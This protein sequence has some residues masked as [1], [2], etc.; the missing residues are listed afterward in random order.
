[1]DVALSQLMTLFSPLRQRQFA[2]LPGD[3]SRKI[4]EVRF[5]VGQPV[6][7]TVSGKTVFLRDEPTVTATEVEEIFLRLCHNAVYTRRDEIAA[8][9]LTAPGG[10]RVGLCGRAVT[11]K[12]VI[13]GVNDLT[14]LNIRISRRHKEGADRL[15]SLLTVDGLLST[16]LFGLPLSGKTTLLR[17]LAY[18]L[19]Q[20]GYRVA[21]VDEREE[22]IGTSAPMDVFRGYPR[23]Q[24]VEQA[25]RLFSPEILLFDELGDSSDLEALNLVAQSGVALF[26]TAHAR[27]MESLKSRPLLRE[28]VAS[29]IFSRYV[30]LAAGENVGQVMA[31]Y[32]GKGEPVPCPKE[33]VCTGKKE[34]WFL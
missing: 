21:V 3:M 33:R 18:G 28:A 7:V 17:E 24:G 1:M 5:R 15:L 2:D 8:G 34:E 6:V 22:L 9:F 31:V 14:S 29:G 30:R 11:D 25:L 12:G 27:D 19:A 23:K 20:K 10:H 16:L 13:T 4:T 26:T 32:D